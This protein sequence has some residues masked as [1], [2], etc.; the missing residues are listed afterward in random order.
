MNSKEGHEDEEGRRF[1][2]YRSKKASQDVTDQ[3][4][5]CPS[6]SEKGEVV[7][8]GGK[9]DREVGEQSAQVPEELMVSEAQ[10][11]EIQMEQLEMPYP[12]QYPPNMA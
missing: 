3:S 8:E 6:S 11:P 5:Y 4:G 2:R 12:L 9:V 1:H 7:G 10:S